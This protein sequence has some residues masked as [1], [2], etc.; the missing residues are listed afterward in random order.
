M[1]LNTVLPFPNEPL[2]PSDA[3]RT[4]LWMVLQSACNLLFG[5]LFDLEV[6]GLENIPLRGAAILAANHQSFLDPPMIGSPLPRPVSFMAKS[7]LFTNPYFGLLIR[8]LHAFP[9]RQGKGDRGAIME[10]VKRLGEGHLLNIYPEGSRTPDGEIQE[11][12]S[13]LALVC[14]KA[15]CP[16]YPAVVDGTFAAWP[17]SRKLPRPSPCRVLYGPG[18]RLWDLPATELLE[19]MSH[20]LK[21]MLADLRGF[22]PGS[23]GVPETAR[24][25]P[26]PPDLVL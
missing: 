19:V 16:I 22:P 10:T 21:V 6:Y 8:N 13:G 12:Q 18:L 1:L 4:P 15:R 24:R 3:R 14:R 20:V 23:T 7:E 5:S 11:L 9:V 2:L 26:A 17:K 25:S